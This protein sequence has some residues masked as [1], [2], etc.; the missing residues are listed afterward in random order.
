MRAAAVD[1]NQPEIVAALRGVGAT[2]QLLHKVGKGCPDLA[3]GWR[4]WNYFLEVK[5]GTKP[6]SARVLTDDQ[7]EWHGG[8]KGQVAVVKSV[9]E[10]LQAIGARV[11]K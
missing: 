11:A 4:G 8:W 5:D 9:D 2:V 3:V 1:A 6:P 7:V 10:A